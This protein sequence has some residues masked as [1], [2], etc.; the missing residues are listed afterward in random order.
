MAVLVL[1][2]WVER[3]LC[4]AEEHRGDEAHLWEDSQEMQLDVGV[5]NNPS[6]RSAEM[7]MRHLSLWRPEG[8]FQLVSGL[9]LI[10][11]NVGSKSSAS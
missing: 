11:S 9:Q 5:C 6:K 4:I 7:L 10:N 8:C 2:Q 1:Q 3:M